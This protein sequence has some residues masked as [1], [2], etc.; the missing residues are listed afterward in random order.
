MT[1][2]VLDLETTIHS[3]FK[4]KGNPFDPLNHVVMVGWQRKAGPVESSY[5]GRVRPA[6]G[7]LAPLLEYVQLLVGHNIKF[8]LLHAIHRNPKNLAAWQ[9]WVAKGG[10]VWDTQLAEYLLN[11]CEKSSHMLDLDEVAPVYG[12]NVK[13]DEVKALW[14]AGV[15]T[16][17]IDRAILTRY[18]CGH[19]DEHGQYSHGD[20]GN[21]EIIFLGQLKRARESKQVK[22]IMLNM[23]SLLCTI[24]MERNGMAVDKELGLRLAEELSK[25]L[26][27]LRAELD[28]FLPAELPFEFKW[29]SRQQLSALIFGGK[30]KYQQRIHQ[31]DSDGFLLYSNKTE[32]Q[33]KLN[34][35]STTP[36]PPGPDSAHSLMEYTVFAGGKNAGEF[37]TKQVTVPDLDKPKLKWED[38]YYEFPRMTEP[39]KEWEGSVEG[40]YSVGAEIIKELGNRNI[41]FLK[42]LAEVIGLTKDLGTY[43]IV[44][45]EETGES[46]GML[47]LVQEDGIIHHSLNHTST[48]TGRF[49]SSNPNLQNIPKGG[50]SDV[51]KVFVSRFEGGKIIQSDF[52]ALEVY[53]QAILTKCHQLIEDLKAGLDMHCVRVA[54]KEGMDYAEVFRLAKT[55]GI[56]EWD[57]KRTKAKVFSFQRAYGAGAAKIAES[58][59]MALEEVEAL[60]KAETD[61]YPE[62]D[63]YYELVT[64]A[65]KRNRRATSK[66]VPHPTLRGA[67]CQIGKSHFVTPDNKRYSYEEQPSP[68]YLAKRGHLTSFSPTEIKNYVVQGAGGEWAKAAMWLAVRYFYLHRNFA[69]EALLVNQVHDALYVDSALTST[70]IAASSLHACMVAASEFMEWWFGWDCPVPVPS[71]TVVGDNMME[72]NKIDVAVHADIRNELRKLYMDNYVP[73]FERT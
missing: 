30:V 16:P 13:F 58:T 3:S 68:E 11:G 70:P 53:V 48:V 50:K 26:V 25:R 7:W 29:S 65:V 4:R 18:L 57:T 51:K 73:T 49:S 55:E 21:T 6:D 8:D 24:E 35:G 28:T 17:D 66:F 38:F 61:R 32:V 67:M 1:Y 2:L 9:A 69:G 46:K 14:A 5:Y 20:I 47:T 27:I 40:V 39:K 10:S 43:Y 42:Q 12:G 44:T 71:D 56:P 41:P 15:N 22:S 45:D 59:G 63:A 62:I 36:E 52:T 33:Y 72:E 23:G 64:A 31:M 60:I 19:T 37:K 34:D 54:Q